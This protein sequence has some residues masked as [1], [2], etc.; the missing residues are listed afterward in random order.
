[1]R[2]PRAAPKEITMP[3]SRKR[4]KPKPHNK[5][6]FVPKAPEEPTPSPRWW[7]IVMV[8]LMVVGLVTVVLAYLFNGRAPLPPLYSAAILGGNGNLALGFVLI[9]AGFLMTLRWK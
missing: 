3:E 4:A 2:R 6:G 9:I 7:V 5:E 8:T 1:M